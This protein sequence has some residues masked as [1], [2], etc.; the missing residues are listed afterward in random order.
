MKY[1]FQF[2][3]ILIFCFLGEMLHAFLPLPIPSSIYGLILLLIALL[4][5]IVK[6]EQIR[7]TS[8]FLTGIF[9]IMFV[10]AAA[11]VMDLWEELSGLLIPALIAVIPVT[12]IVMITSGK[13]TDLFMKNN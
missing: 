4:F 13:V 12:A 6:L 1:L 3:R 11:G 10:P 5:G 7:E 8:L 2:F 9:P